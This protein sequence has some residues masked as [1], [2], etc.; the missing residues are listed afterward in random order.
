MQIVTSH[1]A[2]VAA[3]A[4]AAAMDGLARLG[5]AGAAGGHRASGIVGKTFTLFYFVVNY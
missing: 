2:V 3:A 1:Q 5:D 4:A